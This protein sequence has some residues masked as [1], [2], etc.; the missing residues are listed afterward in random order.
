MSD[1]R[2]LS[3]GSSTTA[4]TAQTGK[5]GAKKSLQSLGNIF[6][7]LEGTILMVELKTGHFYIG[8]LLSS[9]N[10]MNLVLVDTIVISPYH[11]DPRNR[12]FDQDCINNYKVLQYY[13]NI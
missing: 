8:K 7:Y 6:H 9:T 4:A 12:L 11:H 1:M 5:K 2:N 10:D 3:T 13:H